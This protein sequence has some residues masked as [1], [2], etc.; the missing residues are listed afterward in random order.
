M[1]EKKKNITN[2]FGDYS[3]TISTSISPIMALPT[4][5]TRIQKILGV[6]DL[7]F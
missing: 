3:S 7:Q 2:V 1:K 5:S 4:F 6:M